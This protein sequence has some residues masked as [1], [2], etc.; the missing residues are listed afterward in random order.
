MR[1][2]QLALS[3][4]TTHA[5]DAAGEWDVGIAAV[6]N[7]NDSDMWGT[8][9][10]PTA[11]GNEASGDNASNGWSGGGGWKSDEAKNDHQG[12]IKD[13]R[14]DRPFWQLSE[15]DGGWDGFRKGSRC[16]AHSFSVFIKLI[17]PPG[18]G[19]HSYHCQDSKRQWLLGVLG[20]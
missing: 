18:L 7:T 10:K 3:N 1:R 16:V 6:P 17:I 5:A 15:G 8:D 12:Y 9:S 2:G 20:Q 11:A 13:F 19:G 4:N 14:R